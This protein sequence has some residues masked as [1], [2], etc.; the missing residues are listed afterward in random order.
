MNLDKMMHIVYSIIVLI[1][2]I[3]VVFMTGYGS[4]ISKDPN[5]IIFF[6][7]FTGLLLLNLFNILVNL[8][9]Y[10]FKR[11]IVGPRGLKG[12]QGD[13]GKEGQ[14]AKCFCNKS[15]SS[16]DQDEEVNEVN[17]FPLKVESVHHGT[18]ITEHTDDE[19]ERR[20]G[21]DDGNE[22]LE[23][24]NSQGSGTTTPGQDG[25]DTTEGVEDTGTTTQG[26]EGAESGGQLSG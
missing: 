25:A 16:Y 6:S 12:E 15:I 11:D 20:T 10:Y 13:R 18:V 23:L 3:G 26:Q 22:D 8:I 17:S 24:N 1:L 5:F 4:T 19:I 2:I 7:W 21:S 14:D 9:Y